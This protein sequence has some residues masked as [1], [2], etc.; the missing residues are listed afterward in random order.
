MSDKETNVFHVNQV[1]QVKNSGLRSTSHL[2]NTSFH[3]ISHHP[4]S[5]M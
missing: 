3:P 2:I 1:L 4:Q 5:I